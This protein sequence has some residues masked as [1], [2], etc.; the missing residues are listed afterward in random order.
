MSEQLRQQCIET[1]ENEIK[2]DP[3][4]AANY[5]EFLKKLSVADAK[6]IQL[7]HDLNPDLTVEQAWVRRVE[8]IADQLGNP[9]P[10]IRDVVLVISELGEPIS[11]DE[12]VAIMAD[13]G[14]EIT[15]EQA[16]DVIDSVKAENLA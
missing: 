1:L 8:L 9:P 6:E 10:S 12:V 4:K 2:K 3:G 16:Q 14:R 5:R 11:A 7:N 15:E 13:N